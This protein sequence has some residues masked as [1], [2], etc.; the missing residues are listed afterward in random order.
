[1]FKDIFKS[2]E[3]PENLEIKEASR[4]V[5][6]LEKEIKVLVNYTGRYELIKDYH[7]FYTAGV[8]VKDKQGNK[9]KI[10]ISEI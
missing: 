8:M 2:V 3:T 6:K 10:E 1:M 9:F 5:E 4:N 7:E